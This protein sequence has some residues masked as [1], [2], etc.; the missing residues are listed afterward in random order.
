MTAHSLLG[1]VD[2]VFGLGPVSL[3]SKPIPV[4]SPFLNIYK[5]LTREI[6][7]WLCDSKRRNNV[8]MIAEPRARYPIGIPT[9]ADVLANI[10]SDADRLGVQTTCYL[11]VVLAKL[12]A[13]YPLYRRLLAEQLADNPGILE[14]PPLTYFKKLIHEPWRSLQISH[15]QYI[16]ELPVVF[17]Y[18]DTDYPE[19]LLDSIF[20]L[21]SSSHSSPILWIILIDSTRRLP[22]RN[23]LDPITPF[24]YVR[25]PVCYDDGPKDA[26]LILHHLFPASLPRWKRKEMLHNDKKWPSDEQMFHLIRI[27]SGVIESIDAVIKFVNREEGGGPE[28]HLDTF[29][30]YM[31]DSPSP[32]DEQPCCALDHFYTRAFSNIPP[33]NRLIASQVLG[34]IYHSI[35]FGKVTALQITCLLSAV[36]INVP[37]IYAYLSGWAIV[38]NKGRHDASDSFRAFLKEPKRSGQV[39]NSSRSVVLEA[40]LHF[41]SHSSNLLGFMKS[42]MKSIPVDPG[43]YNELE[44]LRHM[45]SQLFYAPDAAS[46]K[47]LLERVLILR[48]DFRCLAYTCDNVNA[49]DFMH[50]LMDLHEVSNLFE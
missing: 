34:I 50:F 18:W 33:H 47:A 2:L 28:A 38:V 41:L 5:D 42:R 1:I 39:W 29:L 14:A 17:L 10:C 22:I 27:T 36:N 6:I 45:V 44:K 32:S 49:R 26:A 23:L 13:R 3:T 21:S 46:R 48:F 9:R 37:N 11:N 16:G 8:Y 15:P 19:A 31:I 30:A 40:F 12:A 24:E 25:I 20:E 7:S 4:Q 43:T 35:Y